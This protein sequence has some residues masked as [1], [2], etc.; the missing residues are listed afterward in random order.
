[1]KSV[2]SWNTSRD[3]KFSVPNKEGNKDRLRKVTYQSI[4]SSSLRLL[5]VTLMKVEVTKK[6]KRER[7]R[8]TQFLWLAIRCLWRRVLMP[9]REC[10]V[11]KERRKHMVADTLGI[12][13]CIWS[14]G[15]GSEYLAIRS[16]L[17]FVV[18]SG[19]QCKWGIGS[20]TKDV[21]LAGIHGVV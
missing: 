16:C 13:I 21:F 6:R 3:S 7:A 1:M 14:R 10:L 15:S 17:V 20:Q 5:P 19:Y 2:S 9:S 18:Y 12:Y 11:G 4:P 8:V